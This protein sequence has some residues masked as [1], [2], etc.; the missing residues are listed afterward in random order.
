MVWKTPFW[1]LKFE[2]DHPRPSTSHQRTK[3]YGIWFSFEA[4]K[5]FLRSKLVT[6]MHYLGHQKTILGF[7]HYMERHRRKGA[8][9][10]FLYIQ[11]LSSQ[12]VYKCWIAFFKRN[13]SWSNEF[14]ICQVPEL[15]SFSLHRVAPHERRSISLI[16][17]LDL[18][19]WYSIPEFLSKYSVCNKSGRD[20]C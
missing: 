2:D 7:L 14:L 4:P 6:L 9:D 15:I 18:K 10:L 13:V 11:F 3:K 1:W 16:E 19:F 12:E 20:L 8:L 17:I 5:S